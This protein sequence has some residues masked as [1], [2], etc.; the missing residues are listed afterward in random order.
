[1][2]QR[3]TGLNSGLDIDGWVKNLMKAEKVPE[4]KMLKTKQT[5]TWKMDSY[6]EAN[7]KLSAFSDSLS[8]LR[9]ASNWSKTTVTSSDPGKVTVT[10]DGSASNIA[11]TISVTS[12]ATGAIK[13]SSGEVSSAYLTGNTDLSAGSTITAGS[14]DAFN[15]SLNGVIKKV[16]LTAG[17]YDFAGLQTAVQAGIDKTFGANQITVATSGN[18]IQ[19]TP[20]GTAGSL[21][22]VTVS[23]VSG[24]TGLTDLGFA[25]QQSYKLDVNTNVSD[26]SFSLTTALSATSGSFTVNGQ[27]IAYT[28]TDSISSVMKKVNNSAAGVNMTYDSITDKF[29][30]TSKGTGVIAKVDLADVSGNFMQAINMDTTSPSAI[31]TGKNAIVTIDGVESSRSS[32]SFTSSGVT[33][34][35]FATTGPDTDPTA[36]LTVSVNK[37]TEAMV[38]NIKNFVTQYNDMIGLLSTKVKDV[39]DKGYAPLSDEEKAAMSDADVDKWETKAKVGLLHNDSMLKSAL[40]SFRSYFSS[41]VQSISTSFNSL[42]S[43][44]VSTKPYNA[45]TPNDAGKIQLDETKLRAAIAEDADGVIN[46]FTNQDVVSDSHGVSQITNKQGIF[47]AMYAQANKTITL[48]SRKAGN[49]GAAVNSASTDLGLQLINIGY[50][51]TAFDNKLSKKEDAYYAKFSAMEKAI[52]NSNTQSN[53][54]YSMTNSNSG[55]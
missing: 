34:N 5:L 33:Y 49:T 41:N 2:V 24:N 53:A 7:T 23:E 20:N 19:F 36:R 13:S 29:S 35:L 28:A 22:Q 21:P 32:N 43:I 10:S 40:T 50:K 8:S 26:L 42:S 48:L 45:S 6:R 4:L 14:N 51:I 52:Q 30:F 27:A 17:T 1:M 25:D 31:V 11:H 44:G 47:Q 37:D 18:A 38:T 15:V 12:L 54:L 46:L 3:I 55:Q 16:T 9:Y 39:Y